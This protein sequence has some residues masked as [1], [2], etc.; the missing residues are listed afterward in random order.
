MNLTCE[1]SEGD[2]I[3]PV[4]RT[5][6]ETHFFIIKFMDLVLYYIF[7]KV[8][9]CHE[10]VSLWHKKPFG[11]FQWNLVPKWFTSSYIEVHLKTETLQ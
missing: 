5:I 4:N 9:E 1:N 3:L 10:V 7:I 11:K 6:W 2:N 8:M